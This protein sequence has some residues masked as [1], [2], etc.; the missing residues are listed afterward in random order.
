M[1][2]ITRDQYYLFTMPGDMCP[3]WAEVYEESGDYVFE[4]VDATGT[5]RD[6]FSFFGP[7]T[8]GMELAVRRGALYDAVV[9]HVKN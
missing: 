9:I 3:V 8:A 4:A 7:F 1:T 2:T 6:R 5:V